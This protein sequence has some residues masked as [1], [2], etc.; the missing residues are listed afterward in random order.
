MNLLRN[1]LRARL[2]VRHAHSSRRDGRRREWRVTVPAPR[3]ADGHS[4]V[5]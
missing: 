1:F 2:A 4:Q 3:V 5:A